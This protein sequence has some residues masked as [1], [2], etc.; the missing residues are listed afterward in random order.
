MIDF[1]HLIKMTDSQERAQW[2][3]LEDMKS[4]IR[5]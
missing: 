1:Q 2:C 3:F 5:T 4:D